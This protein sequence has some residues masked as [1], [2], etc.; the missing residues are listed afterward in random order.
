LIVVAAVAVIPVIIWGVV[1]AVVIRTAIVSV[2]GAAA[3]TS[4]I[5]GTPLESSA[6]ITEA[7]FAAIRESSL[8]A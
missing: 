5:D 2:I 6:A 7:A 1:T 4:A 8:T 3:I